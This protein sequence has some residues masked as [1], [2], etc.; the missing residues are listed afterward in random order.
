MNFK[1]LLLLL[2]FKEKKRK[3]HTLF[4]CIL[5]MIC[6]KYCI[7]QTS[8]IISKNLW[9]KHFFITLE[10][11]SLAHNSWI[12]LRSWYN[13]LCLSRYILSSLNV[14]TV[15][16]SSTFVCIYLNRQLIRYTV[17]IYRCWY[18]GTCMYNRSKNKNI[19]WIQIFN[20]T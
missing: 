3:I 20:L 7:K 15:D 4:C 10:N 11:L 5:T 18:I 13:D 19:L 14:C 17:Y 1:M 2:L 12:Y 6:W 9:H 8:A 16:F